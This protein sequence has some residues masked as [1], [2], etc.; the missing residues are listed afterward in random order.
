MKTRTMVYLEEEEH[1]RLK[2]E[3]GKRHISMAELMRQLVKQ[4]LEQGRDKCPAPHK[5]LLKIISLGSSG[6]SD[7][8]EKHDSYLGEALNREHSH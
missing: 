1:R 3:A 8:S 2:V 4:Y 5:A 7:I 6:H